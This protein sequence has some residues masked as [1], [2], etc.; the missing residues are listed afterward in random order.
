LKPNGRVVVL[1]YVKE[2]TYSETPGLHKMT[3]RQIRA[4]IEPLGFQLDFV[5]DF[6]P[7]QH[8]LIFTKAP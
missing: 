5:L 2:D 4:E 6:L 1:E 8:G 7:L 3:S